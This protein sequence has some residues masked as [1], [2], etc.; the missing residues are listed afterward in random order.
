MPED[1]TSLITHAL[2]QSLPP[3]T[4]ETEAQKE[5]ERL[6]AERSHPH[7]DSQQRTA[8]HVILSLIMHIAANCCK[9]VADL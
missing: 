8:F 5:I 3:Q 1:P 7:N 6:T 9:I 2:V 4:Q